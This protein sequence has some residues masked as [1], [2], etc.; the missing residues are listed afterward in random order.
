MKLLIGIQCINI[1]IPIICIVI[2]TRNL[3]KITEAKILIILP[4]L[5]ILQIVITE[6]INTFF[7]YQN[8][9]NAIS[10]ISIDTYTFIEFILIVLFYNHILVYQKIKTANRIILLLGSLFYCTYLLSYRNIF[11]LMDYFVLLSGLWIEILTLIN[12]LHT[13]KNHDLNTL[14]SNSNNIISLGIFLSYIIIWPTNVMQDLYIN[15]IS[16]YLEFTFISNSLGYFILFSSLTIS[17][18]A[19]GK[20]RGN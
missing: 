13:I 2:A 17:F 9:V 1:L 7:N 19:S 18:Y 20:P 10:K 16:S 11:A 15:N 5:S 4:I 6:F 8:H 12:L 14:F 3:K